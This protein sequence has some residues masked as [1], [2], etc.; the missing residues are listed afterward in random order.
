MYLG[1]SRLLGALQ[2]LKDYAKTPVSE[3]SLQL[4]GLIALDT[5]APKFTS[6]KEDVN[7]QF[8]RGRFP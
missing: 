8:C 7:R 2:S 3:G 6:D 1:R 4:A 5:L